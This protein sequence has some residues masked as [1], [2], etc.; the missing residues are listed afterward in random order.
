MKRILSIIVLA[1]T[2]YIGLAIIFAIFIFLSNFDFSISGFLLDN[3]MHFIWMLV[4]FALVWLY[5]FIV[6][7]IIGISQRISF[8]E[9][10]MRY[11]VTGTT[12]ILFCLLGL[13]GNVVAEEY[14]SASIIVTYIAAI[15]YG[16]LYIYYVHTNDYKHF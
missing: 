11:I 3:G 4:L 13:V 15:I 10:G 8:S 6:E 7:I 1:L 5:R 14:R 9:N 2:S 16:G 12:I